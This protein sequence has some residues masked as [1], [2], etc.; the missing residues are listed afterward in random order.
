VSDCLEL[1][2]LLAALPL[3]VLEPED[4]ARA[5]EHLALC[6]T[7]P[8]TAR[9]L[10]GA[11]DA[12]ALEKKHAPDATWEKLRERIA[13]DQVKP[14]VVEPRVLLACSFCHSGLVRSEAVFCA[15]CL[16]PHHQ[17][18][19]Q[20]H[21]RCSAPGC[22]ETQVVQPKHSMAPPPRRTRRA[23]IL[24]LC[25]GSGALVAAYRPIA[26]QF[27]SRETRDAYPPTDEQ[28]FW[29]A[30]GA[31]KTTKTKPELGMLQDGV[32]KSRTSLFEIRPPEGW[33]VIPSSDLGRGGP[34]VTLQPATDMGPVEATVS[35]HDFPF[36]S[37][38]QD[39]VSRAHAQSAILFGGA[40]ERENWI[41]ERSALD[42]RKGSVRSVMLVD[43]PR[44]RVLEL[45]CH[46][47]DAELEKLFERTCRSFKVLVET[48]PTPS[49]VEDR[50][51]LVR[52]L[53]L[54][55]S[56]R[57]EW[58]YLKQLLEK[59]PRVLLHGWLFSAEAGFEQPC[60]LERGH[61]P[62]LVQSHARFFKPL[63]APP[64]ALDDYDLVIVGDVDESSVPAGLVPWVE[65]GGTL[66]A[67]AGEQNQ[68]ESIQRRLGSVLP[69]VP[70]RATSEPRLRKLRLTPGGMFDPLVRLGKDDPGFTKLWESLPGPYWLSPIARVRDGAREL[71]ETD[72][73]EPVLVA[74]E[75]GK[76]KVLVSLTDETWRWRSMPGM[77][78]T[79]WR[80]VVA[81]ARTAPPAPPEPS[82]TGKFLF[83]APVSEGFAP[84]G[85]A[86]IAVSRDGAV[87]VVGTSCFTWREKPGVFGDPFSMPAVLGQRAY[88]GT[89]GGILVLDLGEEKGTLRYAIPEGSVV[90]PPL[91]LPKAGRVVC[92][93][94]VGDIY[95]FDANDA[96]V[97]WRA[98]LG[99]PLEQAG[100]ALDDEGSAV[101]F[102]G[103]DG[104]LV[105]FDSV[106]GQRLATAVDV[107]ELAA[108]PVRRGN[109]IF[110]ANKRGEL[111]TLSSPGPSA[112]I[113]REALAPG[114]FALAVSQDGETV[115][116][117]DEQG[118]IVTRRP[119]PPTELS[120]A[121]DFGPE[122]PQ[123]AVLPRTGAH[124]EQF[125]VLG[126][127]GKARIVGADGKTSVGRSL[128]PGKL[129]VGPECI[130]VADDMGGVHVFPRP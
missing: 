75:V 73:R 78:E 60:S 82:P 70:S 17:D 3:G 117:A 97:V 85:D 37:D 109:R 122:L 2:P 45:V 103:A 111:V 71:V 12:A 19:F 84:A 105:S 80:N 119:S 14:E 108:P 39:L 112:R 121:P 61:D 47:A 48:A 124:P 113:T 74:S 53:Y 8:G 13:R 86:L 9:E 81:S 116:V 1:A 89:T 95:A 63:Q 62:A 69:V 46:A 65:A 27:S 38:A 123:V 57:W 50:S 127:N 94:T 100:I 77:H 33:V 16:A 29:S 66:V 101:A 96:H 4:E 56:P 44:K 64:T 93:T 54:E 36:A 15:S 11:L 118:R 34:C 129:S 25:L 90:G 58:R 59:E 125:V 87:C 35:I 30:K 98:E 51:Q 52:T 99:V 126:A 68:L 24:A 23:I 42:S 21:G 120:E 104:K 110:F 7:C 26:E 83:D 18:C 106:G 115:L 91:V 92:G 49:R 128:A 6:P 28:A 79:F 41:E 32:Y 102:V 88:V 72:A 10:A 5:R 67:I 76:G 55:A 130:V 22:G 114:P 20:E 31:G 107:G 40:P 43:A